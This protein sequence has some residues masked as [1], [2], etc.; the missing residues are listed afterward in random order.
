[1]SQSSISLSLAITFFWIDITQPLDRHLCNSEVAEVNMLEEINR[2][3][4]GT[5]PG[6]KTGV[7]TWR[8]RRACILWLQIIWGNGAWQLRPLAVLWALTRHHWQKVCVP[9]PL[10][11]V[12]VMDENRGSHSC[13][14]HGCQLFC[15]I[16]VQRN[17]VQHERQFSWFRFLVLFSF[18]ATL[19][20]TWSYISK[21]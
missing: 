13:Q 14:E 19:I 2:K 16:R 1:M 6:L 5:A 3:D 21:R 4:E 8:V 17:F 12:Q 11:T 9:S 15:G 10:T 7:S 20:N 18:F